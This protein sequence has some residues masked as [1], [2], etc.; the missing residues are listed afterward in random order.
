MGKY[1]DLLKPNQDR[2]M[3]F[4]EVL[5]PVE[6]T[7]PAAAFTA[8]QPIVVEAPF[9]LRA[10]LINTTDILEA[11][12]EEA[13]KTNGPI[14]VDIETSGLCFGRDHICGIAILAGDHPVYVSIGHEAGQNI[15]PES[16]VAILR[17]LFESNRR[18]I[19]HNFTFDIPHLTLAGFHLALP[20]SDTRLIARELH[21]RGQHDYSLKSLA[22]EY[23]HP[24]CD[25]WEKQ[26]ESILKSRFRSMSKENLWR[27]DA[28]EVYQYACA[29]VVL[30]KKLYEIFAQL[31]TD[32]NSVEYLKNESAVIPVVAKIAATGFGINQDS[33]AEYLTTFKGKIG[34]VDE[35]LNQLL[36]AKDINYNS[37]KQVLPLLERL[38]I[39]PIN[40]KTQKPSI[41]VDA[42]E[43]VNPKIDVVETLLERKR[44]ENQQKM[45]ASVPNS[46]S[47][48]RIRT[49]LTISA[50][51]GE[52]FSSTG[53]SLYTGKK[54]P[55]PGE[56]TL[57]NFIVTDPDH[58]FGF[59]DFSSSH[60]RILAHLCADENM[61]ELFHRGLD[62]HKNTAAQLFNKPYDSITPK[63]RDRAKP[64][65][66]SVIYGMGD[67][68]LAAKLNVKVSEAKEMKQN[69]LYKIYPKL[70]PYLREMYRQVERNGYVLTGL[71]GV[72]VAVKRDLAYNGLNYQI[73]ATEAEMMKNTLVK[74]D[75]FLKDKQSRIALPF[76]DEIILHLHNKEENLIPAIKAIVEDHKLR[77]PMLSEVK[78]ARTS[79]AEKMNYILP[80]TNERN[81]ET[82]CRAGAMPLQTDK[83]GGDL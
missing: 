69:F 48:G 41:C 6:E 4:A 28:E 25:H 36:D 60:F 34:S 80:A 62:F 3:S 68:G 1:L 26:L 37:T 71:Y 44:I 18:K 23:I 81:G 40:P 27:L 11:F 10:R 38:N 14:Y 52:R 2:Q 72:R 20:L 29:D 16:A 67:A 46:L 59:F 21:H 64:L 73:Q 33:L 79:W 5:S 31:I 49:Q 61:A 45:L 35:K 15:T 17:P 30:T 12:V 47:G 83:E 24:T 63:E 8:E 51:Q 19:G 76:H 82:D 42:L 65:G 13:H 53:P 43:S 70:G 58:F 77:V 9:E 55:D 57:R 75:T 66:F 56:V 50:Q 32:K 78:I 74:L 54:N 39:V 22:C 7:T